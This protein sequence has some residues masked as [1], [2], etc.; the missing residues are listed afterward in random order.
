MALA[1]SFW[2]DNGVSLP[3]LVLPS[4]WHQLPLFKGLAPTDSGDTTSQRSTF[5]SF[6][7][8]DAASPFKDQDHNSGC[9]DRM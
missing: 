9:L 1:L 5:I 2:E 6:P 8:P 7:G 4:L 3:L